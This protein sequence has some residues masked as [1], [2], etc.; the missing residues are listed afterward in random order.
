MATNKEI[1]EIIGL[2][3]RGILPSGSRVICSPPPT[4]TDEDWLIRVAQSDIE[5]VCESLLRQGF[6][7]G[8]SL[9]GQD[10]KMSL[11]LDFWSFRLGTL[12]LIITTNINFF[13]KFEL[14]TKICTKMNVL[15]KR[16][17]VM[18]FEALIHGTYV[19][20]DLQIERRG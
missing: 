17:R 7:F 11:D 8:G 6:E 3:I 13:S 9:V 15:S 18:I 2:P 10:Q 4:D 5:A 16:D 14:A 19:D 1:N 12:N 20:M